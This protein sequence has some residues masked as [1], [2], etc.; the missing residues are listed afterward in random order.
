MPRIFAAKPTERLE[1]SVSSDWSGAGRSI[2]RRLDVQPADIGFFAVERDLVVER[3]ADAAEEVELHFG[4][5]RDLADA[6]AHAA[7]EVHHRHGLRVD[8]LA[9]E[10]AGDFPDVALGELR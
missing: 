2:A 9:V 6:A 10:L 5:H 8:D 1:V 4:A 3:A 7:V